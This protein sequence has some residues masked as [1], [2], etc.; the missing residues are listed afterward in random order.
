MADTKEAASKNEGKEEKKAAAPSA[1]AETGHQRQTSVMIRGK[2]R[3]KANEHLDELQYVIKSWIKQN[4]IDTSSMRSDQIEEALAKKAAD[5][6][7]ELSALLASESS[8]LRQVESELGT[9]SEAL[10]R[11]FV[12]ALLVF[13][14]KLDSAGKKYVNPD[15]EQQA[16]AIREL[17]ARFFDE[18]AP[19]YPKVG[20]AI[21]AYLKENDVDAGDESKV[22][23]RVSVS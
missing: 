4:Q 18:V 14:K 2:Q 22:A 17:M 15:L 11:S 10:V 23:V 8:V 19:T 12:D 5:I 7:R 16:A 21:M 9:G 13:M 3:T 1:V 6:I 20:I